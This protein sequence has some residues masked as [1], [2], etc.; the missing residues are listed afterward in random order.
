A[1]GRTARAS[2]RKWMSGSNATPERIMIVADGLIERGEYR[3]ALIDL[4][5]GVELCATAADRAKVEPVAAYKRGECFRALKQDAEAAVAFQDVFRRYPA[6][7]LAKRAA[8]E[9]VRSLSRVSAA[10]GDKKDEEQMEKLLDE[11]E[12]LGL[13]GE[14]KSFLE[15]LR[16]EAHERKGQFKAAADRFIQVDEACE[17]FDDAMVSAGHCY[18]IDAEQRW[19]KARGAAGLRDE[20]VKQV[21][22]A[23][24]A[25][26]RVLPHKVNPR[27]LFTAYHELALLGLHELLNHPKD[28]LGYL[29]KCSALLPQDS[30]MQGRLWEAEVL[31]LLALKDVE[32]AAARV[33]QMMKQ[34]PDA[35]PTLR[36]CRRVGYRLEESDLAKSARYYRFWLEHSGGLSLATAEIQTVADGLYRAARTL[37][38]LDVKVAS[39][40]DLKGKPLADPAIWK[41][42][43]QARER[44]L[45]DAGLSEKDADVASTL[46]VWCFGFSGDWDK[47]KLLCEKVFKKQGLLTP[48]GALIPAVLKE[49]GWLARVYYEYGH[50]LFQ[51]GKAGQKFQYT[52]AYNVFNQLLDITAKGSEPWWVA[53]YLTL[54]TLFERG[55]GRDIQTVDAILTNLQRNAPAF[56]EGKF[57]WQDKFV[58]LRDQVRAVVAPQR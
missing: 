38:G 50:S 36:A 29:E 46:L 56:D 32:G 8:F 28:S 13:Q 24:T 21:T 23:E 47:S 3:E 53:R 42:A 26:K 17:V 2:V 7:E 18:R 4:R 20:L 16:A 25:L 40:I 45:Q 5:R 49:K 1:A 15:F 39:A 51:L 9:A 57:G 31:A 34:L 33:D 54:R 27:L 11:I 10:T 35:I 12:R 58:E 44:L 22:L 43:A 19:E 41:D 55:E 37:N 6:H 14:A 52:N 30:P 48:A